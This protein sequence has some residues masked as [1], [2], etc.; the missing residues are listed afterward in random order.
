M[1]RIQKLNRKLYVIIS[2]SCTFLAS[3]LS[4]QYRFPNSKSIEA[5]NRKLY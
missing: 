1:T 2:I 5:E 4:H 3:K